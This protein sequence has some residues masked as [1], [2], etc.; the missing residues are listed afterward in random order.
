LQVRDGVT[1]F[2]EARTD[3]AGAVAALVTLEQRHMVVCLNEGG[4]SVNSD[5]GTLQT[6][7]CVNSLLLNTSPGYVAHF[8]GSL[9]AALAKV[10]QERAAAGDD[11]DG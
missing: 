4:V 8:N 6:F 7:D 5:D 11:D 2:E 10:A 9:A 3:G 1:S